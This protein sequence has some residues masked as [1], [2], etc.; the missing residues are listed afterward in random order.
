MQLF[1]HNSLTPQSE[2]V[3]F[4]KE[5][6]THIYKVLRK[7]VG[8]LLHITDGKGHLYQGQIQEVSDKRCI[9][10]L[11][12][13]ELTPAPPYHLHMVVAPTKMNERYEWFLEKAMEIGVQE[14]TPIICEHSERK[15]I[16]TERLEKILL[17]AMNQSL[18]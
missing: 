10:R 12:C 13:C 8:D 16:K 18:Q 11:R 9:V 7:K 6:S 5:E 3:L 1:Y 4:D 14:L 2:I 17:S 15:V